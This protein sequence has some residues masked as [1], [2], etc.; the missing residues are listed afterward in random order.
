MKVRV[1]TSQFEFA[2]GKKPRGLGAW[3]FSI[4]GSAEPFFVHG[5]KY[6]EALREVVRVVASCG[7]GSV[8]VL[9]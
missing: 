5:K 4:N 8:A 7:G 1:S 9:S 6:S 3:A 2:H